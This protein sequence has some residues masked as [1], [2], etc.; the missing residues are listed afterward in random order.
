MY[1]PNDITTQLTEY[2]LKNLQ[3]GYSSETLKF[4]L[5]S[6]G[7]SKITVENALEKANKVLAS[8]IPPIKEKPQITYRVV[9]EKNQPVRTFEISSEKKSFWQKL[10]NFFKYFLK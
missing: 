8:K 4:S 6:Q 1:K 9:N 2:I 3:K 7:Y 10:I 5:I